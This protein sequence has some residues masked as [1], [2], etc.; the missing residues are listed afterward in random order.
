[1]LLFILILTSASKF[2]YLSGSVISDWKSCL[3]PETEDLRQKITREIQDQEPFRDIRQL[4]KNE[5]EFWLLCISNRAGFMHQ[6][7]THRIYLSKHRI[8]AF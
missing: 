6:K 3:P 2:Q 1:M 4:N 8:N 5:V 7:K